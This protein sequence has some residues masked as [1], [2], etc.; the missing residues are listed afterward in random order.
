MSVDVSIFLYVCVCVCVCVCVTSLMSTFRQVALMRTG[1]LL[2]TEMR[3]DGGSPKSNYKVSL[4]NQPFICLSLLNAS[5]E[6]R[7]NFPVI[8]ILSLSCILLPQKG[9]GWFVL[10]L[11]L[12]NSCSLQCNLPQVTSSQE[13]MT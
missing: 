1:A 6:K 3:N 10:C 13:V 12:R 8:F 2:S 9:D 5:E 7:R 11:L 4:T